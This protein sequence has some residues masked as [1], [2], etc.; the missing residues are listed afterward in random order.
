[1]TDILVEEGRV[2][3]VVTDHGTVDAPITFSVDAGTT[4]KTDSG[5][6]LSGPDAPTSIYSGGSGDNGWLGTPEVVEDGEI[7]GVISLGDCVK[8]LLGEAEARVQNLTDYIT[9]Q[10]PA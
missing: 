10:Y 9:G 1:M 2:T 5:V 7:M 6:Q 3:G 8:E 4:G